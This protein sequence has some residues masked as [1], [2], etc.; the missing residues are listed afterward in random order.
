MPSSIATTN[1]ILMFRSWGYANSISDRWPSR[2]CFV[3]IIMI[4]YGIYSKAFET[5]DGMVK[6]PTKG[7]ILN[8]LILHLRIIHG[9][10]NSGNLISFSKTHFTWAN[11]SITDFGTFTYVM[12]KTVNGLTVRTRTVTVVTNQCDITRTPKAMY[13]PGNIA[14]YMYPAFWSLGGCIFRRD[15]N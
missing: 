8:Y 13:R 5:R 4:K 15:Y 9:F 7:T 10:S 3:C 1:W 11:I 6:T 14:G 2:F 12:I